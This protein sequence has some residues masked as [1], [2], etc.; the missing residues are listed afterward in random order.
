[1]R[2]NLI[3]LIIFLRTSLYVSLISLCT[4]H[5]LVTAVFKPRCDFQ[6]VSACVSLSL[7]RCVCAI[8]LL[9]LIAYGDVY[10]SV[11]LYVCMYLCLFI[12]L[13]VFRVIV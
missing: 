6:Y 4:R 13:S 7:R 8:V 12:C 10:L 2:Y 11:Y 9:C 3:Y 5:C 1:M